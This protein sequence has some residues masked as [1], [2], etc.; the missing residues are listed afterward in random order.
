MGCARPPRLAARL[1]L[2]LTGVCIARAID[3]QQRLVQYKPAFGGSIISL[4]LS[5][6][7]PAMATLRPSI[8]HASAPDFKRRPTIVTLPTTGVAQQI[9]TPVTARPFQTTGV[10]ELH[11]APFLLAIGM[12]M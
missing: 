6:T 1:L 12:G 4:I 2:G 7:T 9:P 3:E 8:L 5:N 10:A 11:S